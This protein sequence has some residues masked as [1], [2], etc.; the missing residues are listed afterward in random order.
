MEEYPGIYE[1]T[2]LIRGNQILA[3]IY[4]K[5]CNGL[6]NYFDTNNHYNE[7]MSDDD[8]MGNAIQSRT[9]WAFKHAIMI[10]DENKFILNIA[11]CE[12]LSAM[13]KSSVQYKRLIERHTRTLMPIISKFLLEDINENP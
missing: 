9:D 8:E 1:A 11:R 6:W 2:K 7:P 3:I 13:D 5:R 12:S 4:D 10:Y